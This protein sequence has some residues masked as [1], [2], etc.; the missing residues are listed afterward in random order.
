[1]CSSIGVIAMTEP[2]DAYSR[3]LHEALVHLGE[4]LDSLGADVQRIDSSLATLTEQAEKMPKPESA[5]QERGGRLP[6]KGAVGTPNSTASARGS[7][8]KRIVALERGQRTLAAGT[9]RALRQALAAQRAVKESSAPVVPTSHESWEIPCWLDNFLQQEFHQL[10]GQVSKLSASL[11]REAFTAENSPAPRSYPTS[12]H[13][14]R[15]AI[16]REGV[17]I[18]VQEARTARRCV[19]EPQCMPDPSWTAASGRAQ[20]AQAPQTSQAGDRDQTLVEMME[21]AVEEAE[22]EQLHKAAREEAERLRKEL[23]RV[24]KLSARTK[25]KR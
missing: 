3:M 4:R 8:S 18:P 12:L 11:Q 1:M 6:Q 13:G 5:C 20:A 22:M 19:Q 21:E 24:Q 9:R 23:S 2:T 16:P 14:I 15:P 10:D 7:V 25:N 17:T